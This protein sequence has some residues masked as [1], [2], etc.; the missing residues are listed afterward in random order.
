MLWSMGVDEVGDL[1][2]PAYKEVLPQEPL[3]EVNLSGPDPSIDLD[4][5]LD[6]F[7][8]KEAAQQ[9]AQQTAQ[10]A[11]LLAQQQGSSVRST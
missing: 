7:L 5:L 4:T 6:Q 10:Q 9:A 3:R 8:S 2:N 11:A 1:M